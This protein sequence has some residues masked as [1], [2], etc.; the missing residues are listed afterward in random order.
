MGLLDK[1]TVLLYCL[2]LLLIGPSLLFF[3]IS[4]SLCEREKVTKKVDDICNRFQQID[5]VIM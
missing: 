5:V 4:V 2:K 1:V 3:K